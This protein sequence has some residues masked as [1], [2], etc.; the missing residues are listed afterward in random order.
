MSK[1]KDKRVNV[2]QICMLKGYIT[3]HSGLNLKIQ[4]LQ[5]F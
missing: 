2:I 5:V 4:A 3:G 1:F